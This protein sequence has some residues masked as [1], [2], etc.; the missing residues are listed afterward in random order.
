MQ[1]DTQFLFSNFCFRTFSTY[2]D[3]WKTNA[4]NV[5]NWHF[6][7]RFFFEDLSFYHFCADKGTRL[8]SSKVIETI[9]FHLPAKTEQYN[10]KRPHCKIKYNEMRPS[11]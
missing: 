1:K 9:L 3:D 10:Q 11:I 2:I 6:A 4:N 7:D 8:E 5:N